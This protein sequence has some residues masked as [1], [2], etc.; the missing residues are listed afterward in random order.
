MVRL[1][2]ILTL[3]GKPSARLLVLA[4]MIAPVPAWGDETKSNTPS[5][6]N[7]ALHASSA[8]A[9]GGVCPQRPPEAIGP[10]SDIV[11][12]LD[13]DTL[14]RPRGAEVRF[15][16]VG[17]NGVVNVSRVRVCFGWSNP[18]VTDSVAYALRGSTQIRSVPN[19]TGTPEYG[20]VVPTLQGI[21]WSDWWP[22]RAFY[23][24]HYIFT[25]WFIVPVSDMVV[26]V[27]P[28]EGAP[29]VASVQVGVTSVIV[30]WA[31]AGLVLFFF[32]IVLR[33]IA[34]NR[35]A[36]GAE[37]ILRVVATPDGYA[38]LSQFQ[39]LLWTH[40]VGLSAVYVMVLS[41]NLISIS[42]GTL[43]LL[44]I[45]S[46]AHLFARLPPPGAAAIKPD[47]GL[48]G[49]RP[50]VGMAEP[51][52]PKS[53]IVPEWADLLIPNR[54]TQ[55]IDITRVQM[56]AFTLISAAFVIVKVI[57]DY[58]IPEIPQNFVLLMG[59]SNGVYVG[60]LRLPTPDKDGGVQPDK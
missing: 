45:A 10:R 29:M 32:W 5:A 58:E 14:W 30:G 2:D 38:S 47:D 42:I 7:T 17:R 25:S 18:G 50:L 27:T 11:V 60:G 33:G 37:L 59:I 41:G 9:E 49:P 1:R 34:L 3:A 24:S 26:E 6:D 44:G 56:L 57:V 4:L 54:A 39:V 35:N 15:K 22:A 53:T 51:S 28:S 20:A 52:A 43:T 16:I 55:E 8:A 21:P 48:T 12:E 19:D 46:G 36:G 13:R 40:V 23:P 31:I